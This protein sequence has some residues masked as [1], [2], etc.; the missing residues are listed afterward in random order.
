MSEYDLSIH[1]DSAPIAESLRL[2]GVREA[3]AVRVF[4]LRGVLGDA[5]EDLR[6]SSALSTDEASP[7]VFC[8]ISRRTL[9]SALRNPMG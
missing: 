7:P 6:G 4:D 9:R 2:D 8:A 1:I 3:V 5:R